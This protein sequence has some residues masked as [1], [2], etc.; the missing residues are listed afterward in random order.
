MLYSLGTQLASLQ[1]SSIPKRIEFRNKNILN[2]YFG[3]PKSYMSVSLI[4][5]INNNDI[6]QLEKKFKGKYVLI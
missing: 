6:S 1:D 5:I 3:P 2:P 4:D